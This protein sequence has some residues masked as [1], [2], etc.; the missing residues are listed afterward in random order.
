MPSALAKVL[1]RETRGH[2]ASGYVRRCRRDLDASSTPSPCDFH[3]RW[4]TTRFE[5]D[6]VTNLRI[7]LDL[8]SICSSSPVISRLQEF[9][10]R[11]LTFLARPVSL[12]STRPDGQPARM[13]A[14][15]PYPL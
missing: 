8:I 2:V 9:L 4:A 1:A 10:R 15:P 14:L 6:L 3:W 12:S 13:A 7:A 11:I 5:C